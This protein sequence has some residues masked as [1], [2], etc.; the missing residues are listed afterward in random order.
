MIVWISRRGV[1][2]GSSTVPLP[3]PGSSRD[4]PKTLPARQALEAAQAPVD[5]QDRRLGKGL[6]APHGGHQGAPGG[7]IGDV[8]LAE[9]DQGKAQGQ[10]IPPAERARDAA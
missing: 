10:R 2:S 8:V 3:F 5:R 7:Q 9:I 1:N 6:A 4:T